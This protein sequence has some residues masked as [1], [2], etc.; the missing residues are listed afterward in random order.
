MKIMAV[1]FG[2]AR[3]GLAVCDRTEY[4]AE[5]IGVIHE[6]TFALVLQKVAIAAKEYD[7]AMIVVGYPKNMNGSI[8]PRAQKCADFAEK[9]KALVDIPVELW[10]ERSTTVSAT[11]FLNETNVRGKKRKAVIDEVAATIILESY[12]AYRKNINQQAQQ[13]KE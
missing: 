5:P 8:G 6:K 4:M 1:D 11:Y 3:T 10:D 13:P 7:V 12:L 2:D 9:L